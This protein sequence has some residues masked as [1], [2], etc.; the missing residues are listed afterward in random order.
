[1]IQAIVVI[2]LIIW[3]QNTVIGVKT[4]Y[5]NEPTVSEFD[6]IDDAMEYG[7]LRKT[8]WKGNADDFYK[9]REEE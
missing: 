4:T 5:S 1:M 3:A 9:W 2:A 7:E 6:N 8:G